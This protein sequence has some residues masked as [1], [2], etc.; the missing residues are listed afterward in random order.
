[1]GWLCSQRLYT[2]FVI[3]VEWRGLETNYN[4]GIFLR[5]NREGKPFPD[6][7]WQVNLRQNALGSIMKGSQTILPSTQPIL[8][9]N[10]WHKFRIEAR[11]RKLSLDVDGQRAWEFNNLDTDYGY[12][13]IQ[14]EG[15]AMDLRKLTLKE[16][17]ERD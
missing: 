1:M 11:G 16:L 13:G 17:G 4:S 8:P 3:E 2:N 12:L 6:T 9:H 14:A 5:S 7:G 15:K 10:Q